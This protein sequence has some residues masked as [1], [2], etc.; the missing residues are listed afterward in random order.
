MNP[1]QIGAI[2]ASITISANVGVSY[3]Q[4]APEK[5]DF[6]KREYESQCAVCHGKLGKGDGP[7]AG[8]VDTRIADLTTLAK[9]NNGVFPFQ[10]VYEVVD[11]RQTV[12]AHGPR[13]MPLWGN[14]Y[15]A[16][17]RDAAFDVPYD[18]EAYVRTR[19]LALT[20]YVN[21]LQVK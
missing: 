18:P 5:F 17:S 14:R 11:G 12:K 4:K 7:Y 2:I 6:G 21:R 1:S 19:I 9:K 16:A 20:E 10:K 8:I 3:A 15:L 13:D